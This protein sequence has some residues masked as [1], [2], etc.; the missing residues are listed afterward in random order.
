MSTNLYL[1]EP[2]ERC[3][4]KKI[5]SKTWTEEI[6][7]SLGTSTVEVSQT[8]C[9]NVECQALFDENRLVEIEKIN[10]RKMMKEKQDQARRDNIS[11]TI[12][13]RKA[14]KTTSIK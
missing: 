10:E 14:S 11:K 2:C 8:T 4:S 3:G 13:A 1:N 9:S 7:T 6:Q 12:A 5:I